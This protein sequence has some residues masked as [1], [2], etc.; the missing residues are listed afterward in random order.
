MTE[1]TA[2]LP[3]SAVYRVVWVPGADR[4]RGYCWCG[5]SHEADGPVE[6]WEWLLAHP[7]TH[8]DDLTSPGSPD[9]AA[10]R[11]AFAGISG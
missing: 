7:D 3:G 4:L 1:P 11:H 8:R 9:P 2:M 5:T 10:E 6:L